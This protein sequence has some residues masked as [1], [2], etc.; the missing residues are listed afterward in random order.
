MTVR[1][2]I[3]YARVLERDYPR[4]RRISQALTEW[5][6]DVEVRDRVH[7]PRA[8][9]L[10]GDALRCL[11]PAPGAR[12]VVVAEQGLPYVAFAWVAA[13]ASRSWLVVDG[14][15]GMVE[16]RVQDWNFTS[17]TSLLGRVYAAVDSVAVSLA[18]VYLTD[19]QVRA[20]DVRSLHPNARTV[21]M[22]LP[23]GAPSWAR[24]RP[25]RSADGVLRILYYGNYIPLHGLELA[26]DA[27]AQIARE[28]SVQLTLI[29]PVE[30]RPSAER[31]IAE[32]EL[33]E[34][35]VFV[36]PVPETELAGWIAEHDVVLGVFGSSRKAQTVIANKVWQGLASGTRV[37]TQQSPALAEIAE[38]VGDQ[39]IQTVPGQADSIA[40]GLR[41][42]ADG[43]DHPQRDAHVRLEKY[44]SA[45][46][47]DLAQ[48]LR[49]PRTKNAPR[50]EQ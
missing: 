40:A 30:G 13:R 19:T 32:R 34:Q 15:V 3:I 14:F 49:V 50:L 39:L 21:I 1:P 38:A 26:L 41:Q 7:G 37:V 16:T 12:A 36:D 22:S 46:F 44:V 29:G 42:V 4:F 10:V 33:Q 17:S 20:D 28:R 11:Q 9:R 23:V 35:A 6:Y 27:V 8:F 5:G 31:W 47:E 2:R 24:P 18:D 45:R 48:V 25:P 43:L